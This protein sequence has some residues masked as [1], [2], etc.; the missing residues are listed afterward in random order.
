MFSLQFRVPRGAGSG[1]TRLKFLSTED[2]PKEK[3]VS[4]S[5]TVPGGGWAPGVSQAH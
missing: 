2:N 5:S 4:P 1:F 3:H